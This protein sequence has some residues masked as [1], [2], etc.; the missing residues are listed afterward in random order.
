FVAQKGEGAFLNG[1]RIRVSQTRE[2]SKGLLVTGFPYDLKEDPVN[3]LDHFT[4]MIIEAQAVRRDGSAALNLCYVASGRFDGFWEL[5]LW[6][7]DV[8]AG[9][10]MVK[11]AGG[12]VTDFDG[13]NFDPYG[14]EIVASNGLIHESILKVLR[15]GRRPT[16]GSRHF[17]M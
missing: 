12:R 2:L 1:R 17:P 6:P 10:L 15:K 13:R 5:K 9:A 14:M 8:A 4:N 3:N 11:E 16:T 7:W